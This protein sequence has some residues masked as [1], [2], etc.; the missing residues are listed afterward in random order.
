MLENRLLREIFG[1]KNEE[2][3]GGNCIMQSCMVCTPHK[4]LLK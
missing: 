2:V 3:T 1:P 4:I